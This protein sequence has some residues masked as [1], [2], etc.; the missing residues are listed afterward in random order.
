M[1]SNTVYIL[2]HLFILLFIKLPV[3][4]LG[5]PLVA[6]ALLFK[7]RDKRTCS[8]GLENQRLPKLLSWW[9]VG[10]P[11][12]RK[13]GLNGDLGYQSKQFLNSDD[14]LREGVLYNAV[15]L[16]YDRED[17]GKWIPWY[18][19]YWARFNWLA[20]RNPANGF[21]YNV[22]G[23]KVED[24]YQPIELINNTH[25][26]EVHAEG[27]GVTLLD[28]HKLPEVG[29]WSNAGYRY[30][31]MQT[32]SKRVLGDSTAREIYLV[33][34]YPKWFKVREQRMCLRIRIG[35]KLDHNPLRIHRS[36]VQWVCSINPLKS[37]IGRTYD[38]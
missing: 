18:K 1:L 21:Q 17:E 23:L 13:Y 5:I 38:D 32:I 35:Y 33:Y 30:T 22:L 29:N 2:R 9:D 15:A 16:M 37:Y 34:L 11:I 10:D 26:N 14:A 12:D 31:N 36:V 25:D 8:T 20:L 3:Q 28:F 24:I 19:I 7:I 4:L 6:V 27:L